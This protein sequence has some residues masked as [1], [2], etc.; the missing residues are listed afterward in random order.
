MKKIVRTVWIGLLSGLAFLVACTTT[1]GLSRAEKKQLK[2]E[3][4]EI[5]NQ[6]DQQRQ[7]SDGVKDITAMMGFRSNELKLRERLCQIDNLLGNE[8]DLRDNNN[9][10][11]DIHAEMDSLQAAYNAAHK[12]GPCVYGP[13][14]VKPKPNPTPLQQLQKTRQ[15]LINQY[16]EINQILQRRE[17]ACVYG[18][19]E[20]IKRYGEET[21]RLRNQSNEIAKQIQDIETQI[22]GLENE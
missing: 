14:P 18:S 19:P 10:I 15:D 1:K 21:Q 17:G 9:I 6:I 3:R 11:A 16:Q 13:P 5:L 12:P 8:E 4:I 7:E 20:V 22:K 2:A